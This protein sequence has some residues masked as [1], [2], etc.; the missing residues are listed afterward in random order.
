[1]IDYHSYKEGCVAFLQRLVQTPSVNGQNDEQ[2]VVS[3]VEEEAKKLDLPFGVYQNMIG[4]PNIYIGEKKEFSSDKSLLFIAHTDTVPEGNI[5]KWLFPPF[6]G[7]IAD[8]R[9]HGRGVIDCKSGIALSVYALKILKDLNLLDLAK[10]IGVV[11]EE[12]G[13]NSE[14]GLKYVL[15]KGLRAKGAVYT[16][17]G[18]DELYLSL[19]IGHRGVVRV[20][21]TFKG[22]SAHSG[23]LGKGNKKADNAIDHVNSFITRMH[24]ANLAG[25][26]PYFE[27]RFVA[28][29]T[30]LHGGFAESVIPDEAHVLYDIRTLPGQTLEEI[31]ALMESYA[32]EISPPCGF[33]LQVKTHVPAVLSDPDAAFIKQAYEVHQTTFGND[34]KVKGSGPA[35]ESYMLINKGIP[36]IAGYGLKGGGFHAENEYAELESLEKSLK[37]L[38]RLA[39]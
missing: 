12:S 2:E 35:N 3:L 13:A 7:K 23:F 32:K 4:R 10:F 16:Y 5:S 30:L 27:H 26:N 33:T 8:N 9:L 11:D 28:T 18:G 1:M 36:T 20:K 31:L 19:N 24:N 22:K 29:P 38:V 6:S 15:E 17:G 25:E 21:A 14:Y 39:L 37:F 34:P